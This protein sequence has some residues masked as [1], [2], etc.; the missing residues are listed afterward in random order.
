[1]VRRAKQQRTLRCVSSI[2]CGLRLTHRWVLVG[3]CRDGNISALVKVSLKFKGNQSLRSGTHQMEPP[4][5]F[6]SWLNRFLSRFIKRTIFFVVRL[7]RMNAL[8]AC[9]QFS[10]FIGSSLKQHAK[11][12]QGNV[13]FIN[14]LGKGLTPRADLGDGGSIWWADKLLP[15]WILNLN[16]EKQVLSL[17]SGFCIRKHRVCDVC[18]KQNSFPYTEFKVLARRIEN[19]LELCFAL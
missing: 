14:V 3:V 10:I 13:L 5:R 12:P 15:S 6:I 1:M 11:P 18:W 4:S 2:I 16:L 17:R 19:I 8:A 7:N 9:C